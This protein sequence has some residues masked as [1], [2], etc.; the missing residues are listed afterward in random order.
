MHETVEGS[1]AIRKTAAEA[2]D[3]LTSTY[4]SSIYSEK[5]INQIVEMKHMVSWIPARAPYCHI[6]DNQ[7]KLP[8]NKTYY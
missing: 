3:I 2:I 6:P 7:N 4:K 5:M 1:K 8:T